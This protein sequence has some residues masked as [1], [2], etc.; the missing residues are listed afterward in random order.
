M[1]IYIYMY[2]YICIYICIY[3]LNQALLQLTNLACLKTTVFVFSTAATRKSGG[4]HATMAQLIRKALPRKSLPPALL[5]L[6]ISRHVGG[7]TSCKSH[8]L[9]SRIFKD[10]S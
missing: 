2:I 10:W 4:G 7:S 3:A 1:Y 9:K 6:R 8:S 5:S